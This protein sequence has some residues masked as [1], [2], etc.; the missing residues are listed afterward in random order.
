MLKPNHMSSKLPRT[1]SY[2]INLTIEADC[3][4]ED[5]KVAERRKGNRM[6]K[7]D[8][9]AALAGKALK[10]VEIMKAEKTDKALATAIR[11]IFKA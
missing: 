1:I 2:N 8:I 7:P 6:T 9:I 3:Q 11:E 4:V 5:I 10:A